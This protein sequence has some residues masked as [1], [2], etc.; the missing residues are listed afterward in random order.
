M[1]VYINVVIFSIP[2]YS[3][4]QA[5]SL[6]GEFSFCLA[7]FS[8]VASQMIRRGQCRR[9]FLFFFLR[10]FSPS[11]FLPLP[12]VLYFV[13]FVVV[14]RR[15]GIVRSVVVLMFLTL[16]CAVMCDFCSV[17]R[18]E[19]VRCCSFGPR[20]VEQSCRLPKHLDMSLIT[21][22]RLNALIAKLSCHLLPIRSL[23]VNQHCLSLVLLIISFYMFYS[24]IWRSYFSP[25]IV[26]V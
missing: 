14:G 13:S 6:L 22:E 9:L 1:I 12:L 20:S 7:S 17:I 2:K 26:H 21:Y 5:F 23:F 3:L 18:E 15:L 24:Y 10:F 4:I 8:L 16:L 11:F 19:I 25:L